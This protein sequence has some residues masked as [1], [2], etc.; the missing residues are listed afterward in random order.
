MKNRT[1][2]SL[3]QLAF[4]DV[5]PEVAERLR[6]QAAEDPEMARELA[7]YEALR[8]GLQAQ[9]ANVPEPRVTT[10]SLR[11]A[12]LEAGLDERQPRAAAWGWAW[13]PVAVGVL[14]FGVFWMRNNPP[15]PDAVPV[16][17]VTRPD[18]VPD[19]AAPRIGGTASV[20]MAPKV[21]VVRDATPRPS[22]RRPK[23]R[24]RSEFV[25]Y[26][27]PDGLVYTVEPPQSV[28]MAD[29]SPGT[30][31]GQP[32]KAMSAADPNAPSNAIILIQPERNAD[33]GTQTATEV[34]SVANVVI[35][36]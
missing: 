34:E 36:G 20:D 5:S 11:E 13:A 17:A 4:G 3:A 27:H 30:L 28:A 29:V 24:R 16:V 15:S 7:E 25:A 18:S 31:A 1:R 32:P 14:A 9:G 33:T 6:A 12:I 2:Q 26:R 21:T 8:D 23:V 10:A 19:I 22:V 35:G